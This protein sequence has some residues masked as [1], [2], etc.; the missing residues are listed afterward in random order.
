MVWFWYFSMIFGRNLSWLCCLTIFRS[1]M[2]GEMDGRPLPQ[3]DVVLHSGRQLSPMTFGPWFLPPIF[4]DGGKDNYASTV[5]VLWWKILNN[6]E[7]LRCIMSRV[8]LEFRTQRWCGFPQQKRQKKTQG[9]SRSSP[10]RWSCHP[11]AQV[12]Q[13]QC[14]PKKNHRN[15]A[16]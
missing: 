1:T 12:V 15:E 9:G 3:D 4:K 8:S 5:Q 14:M 2:F 10:A 11:R 16:W 6:Y 7:K 13:S